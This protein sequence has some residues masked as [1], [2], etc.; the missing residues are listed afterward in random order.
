MY[1]KN[2]KQLL[3]VMAALM[4]LISTAAGTAYAAAATCTCSEAFPTYS[5]VGD[6]CGYDSMCRSIV[7]YQIDPSRCDPDGECTVTDG[8]TL[9]AW[10]CTMVVRCPTTTPTVSVP[11]KDK[12][13]GPGEGTTPKVGDP[14]SAGGGEFRD[15]WTLLSLGGLIPIDFT[16]GYM[17]DMADKTPTSDRRVQFPPSEAIKAFTSNTVMRLVEFTDISVSPNVDYINILMFNDLLVFKYDSATAKFLPIGP[18]KYQLEKLDSNYFL[19]NPSNELVYHFGS[20]ALTYNRT[21]PAQSVKRVGEIKYILDRNNSMVSYT[22]NSDY[23]PTM[24]EENGTGRKLNLT[25][26]NGNLSSVSDSFGRSVSF[27]YQ[28]L[29]CGGASATTLTGFTDA[30]GQ[31]TTF[32]YD[33]STNPCYLLKKINR[34]MGNSLIDQT[35]ASNPKGVNG[36]NSQKDAYNNQTT[37]SWAQDASGNLI[38]TVTNPDSTQQIFHHEAER[39]P[40]DLTDAANKIATIGYTADNQ[41]SQITDRLGDTTSMTYHPLSG[42]FASVTNAE[43]K[44]FTYTYTAQTQTFVTMVNFTFYDLTRTDYPDGANEQSVYDAKGNVISRTDRSGKAWQYTYNAKG[45]VLTAMNPAGGVVTYTYNADGTPAN[46]KDSETGTTAYSYDTYKRVNKITNPDNST[47]QIVYDFSDR[48]TSVTDGNGKSYASVYDSNNNLTGI[49]D[50]SG[51]T[52]QFSYDNMDRMTQSTDRLAMNTSYQYDKMGRLQKITGPSGIETVFGYN[53]RGWHTSTTH[54]GKQ[55]SY[56]YDDEGVIRTSTTPLNNTTTFQTD[57]LGLVSSVT[58]P[59]NQA[60]TFTRDSLN[61]VTGVTDPLNRQTT[62]GYDTR[63]L[64]TRVTM[65]VVGTSAYLYDDLGLLSKVTDL[66]GSQWNFSRSNM[67]RLSGITDPLSRQTTYTYDTSGRLSQIN[68]PDATTAAYTY[69]NNGNISSSAYSGGV[70]INNSYDVEDR[71]IQTN[72]IQFTR[73]NEG[74]ITN[75]NNDGV[76]FEAT[77]NYAGQLQT[78]SYNNSLFAVNY[79]YNAT[80]GLLQTISDTLTGTNINFSYDND[81]RLSGM[82]RTNGV[83]GAYS[84]DSAGRVTRLQEGTIIDIQNSY[85]AAGEI[86]GASFVAPLDPA[87]YLVSA[88][89]TYS[90]DGASQINTAGYTFDNQGR[91]TAGGGATYTWDAASRLTGTGIANITYNGFGDI[92]TRSESGKNI[93]YYYNHAI[94]LSPIMAEKDSTGNQFLRYYVWTPSGKLLYVIDA[95]DGNSVYYYHF[96]TV[97]STLAL[98]NSSGTV[99]HS[100]AYM[101]Y[102]KVAKKSGSSEQAFTFTGQ[103]GVRQEG[104]DGLYQMRA[105]YYDSETSRFISKEPIW[106][107]IANPMALNPYQYA[108]NNPLIYVDVTG[109]FVGGAESTFG[110]EFMTYWALVYTMDPANKSSFQDRLVALANAQKLFGVKEVMEMLEEKGIINKPEVPNQRDTLD[111]LTSIAKDCGEACDKKTKCIECES[112]TKEISKGS[113][114]KTL[115]TVGAVKT[116]ATVTNATLAGKGVVNTISRGYAAQGAYKAINTCSKVAGVSKARTAINAIRV[117]STAAKTNPWTAAGGACIDVVLIAD[118][119]YQLADP[120]RNSKRVGENSKLGW[121]DPSR[122]GHEIGAVIGDA[123]YS[124]PSPVLVH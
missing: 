57:K 22:Y 29:T 40:L 119:I 48:L 110:A 14:I 108:I 25:Y 123:L 74:R 66:M 80:T 102:G 107:Q 117:M 6:D 109:L 24:I 15:Y 77:Y 118:G 49:T 8:E 91:L 21:S 72:G 103:Y 52:I 97:G 11:G 78:T 7:H 2:F 44:T 86:T 36:V 42:K 28:T 23:L 68:N 104:G 106:P 101:P 121:Y 27:V 82:T 53:N 88:T 54:G 56:G 1:H 3:R 76:L 38:T 124:N 122:W 71:L 47:Y 10:G 35:W 12:L 90:Y 41:K 98:T 16:L 65:P 32:E 61:R 84:Y 67:G 33:T 31:Q 30:M 69:D 83:N 115:K 87:Q 51:K 46:S 105:R 64:L 81:N 20:R 99:T 62:F 17:P 111:K 19:M 50:P 93:T 4:M 112:S 75:T 113:S 79:S 39:Y 70:T 89:N 100:Y 58:D 116:V 95:T 120:A 63:G 60:M 55:W 9:S 114:F 37:L 5:G 92:L 45:Q 96:D 26:S 73:D 85:N 34:P 18:I 43:G 13:D 94:D 59:L